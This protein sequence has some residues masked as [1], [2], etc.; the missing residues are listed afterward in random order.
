ML[1]SSLWARVDIPTTRERPAARGAVSRGREPRRDSGR[2]RW[3]G[4]C[5]R[6]HTHGT[7]RGR[8]WSGPGTRSRRAKA[9]SIREGLAWLRD[10][11]LRC[12]TQRFAS[13]D[14]RCCVPSGG[15]T[16]WN[17]ST[18]ADTVVDAHEVPETRRD[19]LAPKPWMSAA[20]QYGRFR[21]SLEVSATCASN[22]G[23]DR[24]RETTGRRRERPG[25]PLGGRNSPF[26]PKST[27]FGLVNAPPRPA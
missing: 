24:R 11:S 22:L 1:R 26:G 12:S 8:C 10:N 19:H 21:A 14:H 18:T 20:A 5:R 15:S 27:L 16:R 7:C 9:G 13:I 3:S 6:R 23:P 25:A 17:P 4:R 2:R